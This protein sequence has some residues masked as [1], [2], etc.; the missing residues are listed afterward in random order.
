MFNS[1]CLN[2]YFLI[3]ERMK[4]KFANEILSDVLLQHRGGDGTLLLKKILS[5][6]HLI[7]FKPVFNTMDIVIYLLGDPIQD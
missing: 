5:I 7:K 4:N 3:N 1:Q 6:T 2:Q